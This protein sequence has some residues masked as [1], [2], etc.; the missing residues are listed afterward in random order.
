MTTTYVQ[1]CVEDIRTIG[2]DDDDDERAH[3]RE[4]LLWRKVLLAIADGS[5]NAR[6]LA[7]E[8]LKTTEIPFKRWYS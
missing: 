4:D 3:I 7:I 6:E 8:A 1:E 5:D 2:V